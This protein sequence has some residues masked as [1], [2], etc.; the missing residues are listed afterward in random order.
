[1]KN[2]EFNLFQLVHEEFQI[3]YEDLS[4]QSL[5]REFDNWSSLSALLF[6]SAITEQTG[7]F[8]SSIDLS[9]W[10]TLADIQKF[11]DSKQHG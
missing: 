6:I 9:K 1:M 10:H 7:V 8:I 11:I 5:F 2:V 3:A 4:D